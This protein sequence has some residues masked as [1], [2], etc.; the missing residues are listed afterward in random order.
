MS[1]DDSEFGKRMGHDVD[2]VDKASRSI[3]KGTAAAAVL[4]G[5]TGFNSA[6]WVFE[7][8]Q[9]SSICGHV[10]N[11]IHESVHSVA[12]HEITAIN[13]GELGDLVLYRLGFAV[14]AGVST[15]VVLQVG[16]ALLAGEKSKH[17]HLSGF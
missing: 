11:A 8:L 6:D 2:S 17:D 13:D 14:I 7:R 10:C 9:T 5:F 16:R 3:A 15:F 12:G 4:G 1:I